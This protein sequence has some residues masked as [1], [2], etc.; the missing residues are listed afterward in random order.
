MRG[1]GFQKGCRY[2][3]LLF[4]FV[5]IR[6]QMAT[7]PKHGLPPSDVVNYTDDSIPPNSKAKDSLHILQGDGHLAVILL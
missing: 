1:Y 7:E 3:L 5:V 2:L 6:R 4:S